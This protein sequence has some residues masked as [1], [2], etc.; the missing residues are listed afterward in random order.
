M[1]LFS[2]LAIFYFPFNRLAGSALY[3]GP[4][5]AVSPEIK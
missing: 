5:G 4:V 1:A 2:V 3:I